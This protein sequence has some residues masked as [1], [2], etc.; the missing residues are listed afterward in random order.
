MSAYSSRRGW[1]AGPQPSPPPHPGTP[2]ASSLCLPPSLPPP[3]HP[4]VHPTC[5][6]SGCG[7]GEG[8][9]FHMTGPRP[10]PSPGEEPAPAPSPPFPFGAK[11]VSEQV[12]RERERASR[13]QKPALNIKVFRRSKKK[14]KERKVF[15]KH[16]M[17]Q[18]IKCLIAHKLPRRGGNARILSRLRR[19]G[20]R[21]P[22]SASTGNK[23]RNGQTR[24]VKL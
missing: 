22:H 13:Q 5:L 6:P 9:G 23:D 16:L 18:L 14:K 19:V 12:F 4:G 8:R 24:D 17:C 1:G 2:W 3:D 15:W 10:D 20:E 21:A 7:G 11:M